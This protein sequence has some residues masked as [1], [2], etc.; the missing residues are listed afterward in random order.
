MRTP[1]MRSI[2][3]GC[4]LAITLLAL[5][6]CSFADDHGAPGAGAAAKEAAAGAIP[7]LSEEDVQ[8]IAERVVQLLE[9]RERRSRGGSTATPAP[10]GAPAN[11]PAP[12]ESAT[13]RASGAGLGGG[14]SSA[15]PPVVQPALPR[16]TS[17]RSPVE[18]GRNEA[19]ERERAALRSRAYLAAPP[20]VDLP[21]PA[22]AKE[23]RI[24]SPLALLF[25]GTAGTG[26]ERARSGV[27]GGGGAVAVPERREFLLG[28]GAPID[29]PAPG[30]ARSA[31]AEPDLDL[32]TAKGHS[33][34][35]MQE[36]ARFGDRPRSF[37]L[38]AESG[39]VPTLRGG[40]GR[41][42]A[43]VRTFSDRQTLRGGGDAAKDSAEAQ[44]TEVVPGWVALVAPSGKFSV[45]SSSASNE[46]FERLQL[47]R[48]NPRKKGFGADAIDLK[49]QL[50]IGSFWGNLSAS[51]F[52][53]ESGA[54]NSVELLDAYGEVAYKSLETDLRERLVLRLGKAHVPVGFYSESDWSDWIWQDRPIVYGRLFNGNLV[55]TGGDLLLRPSVR[56]KH[57]DLGVWLGAANAETELLP[58]FITESAANRVGFY[59]TSTSGKYSF[60]DLLTFADAFGHV[61]LLPGRR[62]ALILHGGAFGIHGPN[63]TGEDGETW[64]YGA[65][66]RVLW[67]AD[68]CAKRKL[69]DGLL[70]EGE[71]LG[72]DYRADQAGALPTVELTDSGGYVS[73]VL[74]LNRA[75]PGILTLG[76]KFDWLES[77]GANFAGPG[78]VVRTEDPNRS[79]RTRWSA[80]LAWAPEAEVPV[81]GHFSFSLQYNYDEADFLGEA[82]HSLLLGFQ[83]R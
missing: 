76:G 65:R 21:P 38:A 19:Y 62:Q 8:R 10:A 75:V 71:W 72:R 11:L 61:D 59:P 63:G 73:C 66:A 49:N 60:S 81:L 33:A 26:T 52:D 82:K 16:T 13:S 24:G 35:S 32:L 68:R 4:T 58:G 17:P 67:L 29:R 44:V 70:L 31:E 79:P 14:A 48:G 27:R 43:Y 6:P 41:S 42:P 57:G 55:T 54:D 64:V 40:G 53:Q 37:L 78:T 9:D 46:T 5:A 77:S 23:T 28:G 47:G 2:R 20:R 39:A 1:W 34:R 36:F 22:G 7:K 30:A 45:T 80:L 3:R 51:Y 15:A 18:T 50:N 83:L 74:T 69:S 25:G 12:A 56:N